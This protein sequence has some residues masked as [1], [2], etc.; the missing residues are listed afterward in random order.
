MG[1]KAGVLPVCSLYRLVSGSNVHRSFGQDGATDVT[2]AYVSD[3][4][5]EC[6][7]RRAARG[8]KEA[9]LKKVIY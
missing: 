5:G 7:R 9:E 8:W 2:E 3:W 4:S 1:K 6:Q